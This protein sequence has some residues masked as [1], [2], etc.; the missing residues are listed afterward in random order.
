MDPSKAILS[1]PTRLVTTSNGAWR[2]AESGV[3]TLTNGELS[4]SSK[5]ASITFDFGRCIGGIPTFL[6][7]RASGEG[8]ISARIFYSETHEGIECETG[9]GPYFF[10]SNA[11]DCYRNVSMTVAPSESQQTIKPRLAQ[12]SQRYLKVVLITSNA[13]LVISKFGFESIRPTIRPKASFSC[14]DEILN[15]IWNDGVN[16]LEMCTVVK[17]ETAPAWDITDQGTRVLGQH[18]A[19]CRQGTRWGDKEVSFQVLVEEL[20]ASWGVHMV[21]NGV[22]FCLDVIQEEL[23]AFEGMSHV[24]A[25]FPVKSFGSWSTHGIVKQGEWIKVSTITSGNRITVIIN[26]REVATITDVQIRPLLG[27]SGINTGSVAFGG[28]EGWLALYRNLDV[29]DANG[30]CLYQNDLLFGNKERTL[31]DFQVGTN[32]VSCMVDGAKRDRATFGGDLFVSGRGVAYSG[33]DS[34]A[35]AGSIEL[36]ASHQTE[37]GYLGN[38]CPIQAP[39]HAGTEPPPTYA[40]YSM[41]YALLLVVAIKDYWLSS[42]DHEALRRY[43]PAAEKLLEYAKSQEKPSGLIEVSPDMSMHWYPL[44]GPVFG[45]SGT[46]NLAY[47][48]ALNAVKT[49]T[50]DDQRKSQLSE[51]LETLRKSI[52]TNLWNS[53]KG[54]IRMGSALPEE[55]ICQDTNGYAVALD[56]A[57]DS[58]LCASHLSGPP[59]W[60]PAAFKGLQHW[61]RTGVVSPYATGF[62]VE[63]LF[64]RQKGREAIQLIENVWGPMADTSSPNYSGGH[65]EAMTVEGK[66][67][68]H[69]TSLMHAWSCWPVFLLPQYVVGVKPLQPG[70]SKVQL[71]PVLSGLKSAH[72]RTELSQGVLEVEVSVDETAGV[73][74]IQ[75][76]LP[77]GT[78]AEIV[79]PAGYSNESTEGL[80]GPVDKANIT[81]RR[82]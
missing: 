38:L 82:V 16:T 29:R 80:E 9:D 30:D 71:A 60:L 79:A 34:E 75:A 59:G 36:L 19:P 78:T 15:R 23:R 64:S 41:T 51:K 74:L 58:D 47:Y 48:D 57:E 73:I 68:G 70:W 72:Y 67:F 6:V 7:D 4:G 43:L 11:M 39:I 63:A 28:P 54:C 3:V 49:M 18:W 8:P 26:E 17:G 5:Q 1:E 22:I 21:A 24:S 20:G 81:L 25:V 32:A 56:V 37:A 69:D 53:E 14:S 77:V 13:T 27:G 35:V 2:D 52:L 10:F 50:T 31:A 46:T 55:G 45:A 66:P 40:F 65:W 76:T 33:M 44:G 62:A 42:G 61:D 12:R